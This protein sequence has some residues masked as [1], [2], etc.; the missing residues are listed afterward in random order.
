MAPRRLSPVLDSCSS[1]APASCRAA[2][3]QNA[4]PGPRP[5]PAQPQSAARGWRTR[6]WCSSPH[7]H[8]KAHINMR[9]GNIVPI[10][11]SG[12]AVVYGVTLNNLT[13]QF[14]GCT[15]YAFEM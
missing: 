13:K 15:P 12:L 14:G 10:T 1:L 8:E 5:T 11:S 9:K 3:V 7:G 2:R 4:A 6:P